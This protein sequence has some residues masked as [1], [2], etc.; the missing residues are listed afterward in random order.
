[1]RKIVNL[2]PTTS[3]TAQPPRADDNRLA[4]L[5]HGW[6]G[7]EVRA[8]LPGVPRP[9]DNARSSSV[10]NRR[11]AILAVIAC[12]GIVGSVARYAV[13]RALPTVSGHFPWGTFCV[14]VTGS[15]AL[16]LLLMVVIQLLP[17]GHIARPLIGT[18]VIGAYTTFS[19]LAGEAD[20]LVHDGH[21]LGALV[22][23]A[24]SLAA[25][26]AAVVLGMAT[27]RAVVKGFRRVP[28]EAR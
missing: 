4:V 19:T 6:Q 26:L 8:S 16:G 20:L 14:N 1:V 13:E 15:A 2:V 25:G 10:V 9:P 22:Y 21:A 7:E 12:G 3:A 18:G 5:C 27:G 11:W 23:V 17:R 28:G 24:A